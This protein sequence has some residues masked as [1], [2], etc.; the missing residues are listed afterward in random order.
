MTPEAASSASILARS[1]RRRS[2]LAYL[3]AAGLGHY[4]VSTT[5]SQLAGVLDVSE[6]S[7]RRYLQTLR[8][9]GWI[10]YLDHQGS[11]R[12]FRTYSWRAT[13]LGHGFGQAF[14]HGTPSS[15]PK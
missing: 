5:N 4:G 13:H 1:S 6:R 10:R 9:D 11:R 14:G 3:G 2:L 7:V 15:C 12:P 8:E